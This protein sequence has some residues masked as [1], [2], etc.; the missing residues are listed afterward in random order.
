VNPNIRP[1]LGDRPQKAPRAC[2]I[3]SDPP[4]VST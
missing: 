4:K 2:V 3:A 1:D